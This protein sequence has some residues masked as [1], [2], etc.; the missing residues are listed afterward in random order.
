M[1]VVILG[2][3]ELRDLFLGGDANL[4]TVTKHGG[5]NI[6]QEGQDVFIRFKQTP[7]GLQLHYLW[8]RTLCNWRVKQEQHALMTRM[9]V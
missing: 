6:L 1:C 7:H 5:E 2:D 4:V 9:L 3:S 8:I